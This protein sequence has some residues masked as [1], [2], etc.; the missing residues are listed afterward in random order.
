MTVRDCIAEAEAHL[1][2]RP[3]GGTAAGLLWHD[4]RAILLHALADHQPSRQPGRLAI[5]AF[6]L[7]LLLPGEGTDPPA[8]RVALAALA[9]LDAELDRLDLAVPR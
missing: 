3:S 8:E 6:A 4:R 9:A 1:R 7:R 5:A 2:A